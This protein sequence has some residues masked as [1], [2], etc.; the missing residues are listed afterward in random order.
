LQKVKFMGF[1]VLLNTILNKFGFYLLRTKNYSRIMNPG[2][3]QV[4]EKYKVKPNSVLHIGGHFAEEAKGYKDAGISR[5]TFIEGDPTVY[6][7]MMQHLSNFPEYEGLCFLLSKEKGFENFHIASN[8]GA[9]SS[10][11]EPKSHLF[12]EP[13]IKFKPAIQLPVVT[14]DSLNLGQFDLIVLDVQGAEELVLQG[15]RNTFEQ[16][17]ALWIEVSTGELYEGNTLPSNLIYE[18]S[19]N[20]TPVHLSMGSKL[21]GDVL[22][23][24]NSI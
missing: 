18:L 17:K 13:K 20:F 2:P 12:L 21:W 4:L 10:L 14:L 8:N 6:V 16:A 1:G 15:G 11:L 5:V 3:L 23:L 19:E 9:S 7:T 24:R 22:F